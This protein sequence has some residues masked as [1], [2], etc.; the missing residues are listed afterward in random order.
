MGFF[1][2]FIDHLSSVALL[3]FGTG[4]LGNDRAV[5]LKTG[6]NVSVPSEKT[7]LGYLD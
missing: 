2:G 3:C 5:S 4:I 1:F 7:S 6:E